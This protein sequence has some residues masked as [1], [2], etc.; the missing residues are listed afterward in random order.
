MKA[1]QKPAKHTKN[2]FYDQQS[3]GMVSAW[4]AQTHRA[5]PDLKANDKWPNIDG[6]IELTDEN[7][8]GG[9][10]SWRG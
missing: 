5:M 6:Y 1:S 7:G 9:R 3:V 8:L 2:S 10:T 4:I